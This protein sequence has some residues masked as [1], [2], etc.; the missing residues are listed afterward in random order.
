MEPRLYSSG[1][2]L[3]AGKALKRVLRRLPAAIV[4]VLILLTVF[5][6]DADTGN[7]ISVQAPLA[8]RS[9]LLDAACVGDRIWAVGERGHML[10]SRDKGRSWSQVQVP[11]RATLTGVTFHDELTGWAVGHEGIILRTR[12]G[13]K[14]WEAVRSVPDD[15]RPLLDVWFQDASRGFA[16]GAYG[17]CLCTDDGGTSWREV[18]ISE[19][20]WH[21]HHMVRS[22]SGRLY[23][24]AESGQ[25]YRSDD[26]G[27]T[28]IT[29]PSPYEGSFF[30]LIPLAKDALLVFGLRGHVFRSED[31]GKTWKQIPTGTVATL[32][33]GLRLSDGRILLAGLAGTVLVSQ[34]QDMAFEPIPGPGRLGVWAV[35]ETDSPGLVCFGE[36]GATPLALGK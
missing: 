36:Q 30:G 25:I 21:L 5:G 31:A 20:D 2:Y 19:D 32:A 11:T 14:Q 10:F 29:L 18:R 22:K 13:G 27:A 4:F 33:D 3:R 26:D 6:T 24:A 12:D 28:W 1:P 8:S 35:I 7:V 17:I 16:I 9:L 34:E 23:I 15:D